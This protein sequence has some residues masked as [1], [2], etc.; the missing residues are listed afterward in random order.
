MT[1][2]I[3]KW[4]GLVILILII[5]GVTYLSTKSDP[6]PYIVVLRSDTPDQVSKALDAVLAADTFIH[7]D[8]RDYPPLTT[9]ELQAL[10]MRLFGK[11]TGQAREP[12][13]GDT[14]IWMGFANRVATAI[15]TRIHN[16]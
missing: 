12:L 5:I 15:Q 11:A 14:A 6:G 2:K 7:Y 8:G 9:E 10:G 4:F 13:Q 3:L 1:R 16:P